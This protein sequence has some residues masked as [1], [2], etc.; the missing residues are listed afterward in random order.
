MTG[1]ERIAKKL[2]LRG[3]NKS[4]KDN[5]GNTPAQEAVLNQYDKIYN[6]LETSNCLYEFLN[7][8][9]KYYLRYNISF[10]M[11]Q[12]SYSQIVAFFFLYFYCMMGTIVFV[13]PLL[14]DNFWV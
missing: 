2:L 9:S 12:T 8:R 11:A 4:I 3:A 13:Y 14:F 10:K 7:I 5:R 1:N 6:L